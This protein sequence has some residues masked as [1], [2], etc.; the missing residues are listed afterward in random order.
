M[1]D[2]SVNEEIT[3]DYAMRNYTIDHFPQQCMCGSKPEVNVDKIAAVN[4]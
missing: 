1:K 3:F 2:I 4:V